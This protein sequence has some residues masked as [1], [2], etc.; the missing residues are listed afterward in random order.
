VSS[1]NQKHA[2]APVTEW[3]QLLELAD[4]AHIVN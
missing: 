3:V 1:S 2:Q 4:H